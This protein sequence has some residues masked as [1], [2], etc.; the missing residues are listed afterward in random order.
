[1]TV[2]GDLTLSAI[3][4]AEDGNGIIVRLFNGEYEGDAAATLTFAGSVANAYEV[5]L[6]ERKVGEIRHDD[7]AVLVGPIGHAKIVTVCIELA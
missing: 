5:D 6:R 7:K 3:K 4:K 2:E 1:M